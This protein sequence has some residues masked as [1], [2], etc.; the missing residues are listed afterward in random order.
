MTKLFLQRYPG[1]GFS[2]SARWAL[3]CL[4]TLCSSSAVYAQST[5]SGT[6]TDENGAGMPGVSILVKNTTRGTTSGANGEYSISADASEILV[7]SF[8]GYTSVEETVGN[9]TSLDVKLEPNIEALNEVVVIGY[10]TAKKS[11]VTGALVR[12]DEKTI[13]DIPTPSISLAMQGRAAG[14]E[15]QRT[16]SRP[17]AETQIRIRGTRS[18]GSPD[19][20]NNNPLIVVDGIPYGGNINDLNPSDIASIDILKDASATAIYGSRGSNGVILISTK[21]GRPG[22][23]EISYDGYVGVASA[24]DHYDVYNGREYAK[25]VEYTGTNGGINGLL[26]VERE[27]IQMGRQ[28]D[29]QDLVYKR[30]I[31]TNHDISLTG[32]TENTRFSMAA[33]YFKE[34]TVLPGQAFQRY[35]IRGTLDQKVGD[36][37]SVGLNTLNSISFRDGESVDPMFQILTISPL[38][39]PYD[40]DGNVIS[41]PLINGLETNLRS[42]LLL[43]DED[44]W[45]QQ[46]RRIRTF[47]SLYG[48]VKIVEGLRYRVN[49]GLDFWQDEYGHFYGANTPM[50]SGQTNEAV[51]DNRDNWMYTLENLLL[52]DK[53]FNE[54][55]KVNFTGLF[56]VQEDENNN[57]RIQM[58]DVKADFLQYYNLELADT[59]NAA[60]GGYARSGLMSYMARAV[61][62]FDDRFIVTLTGRADGSSRLAKGNKWFYYPAAALAWN[63]T[64]E[65]FMQGIEAVSNL[66]V[67]AGFGMTSNQA[68]NPY[69]SL[70]AL[71][72]MPYSYGANGA[73]GFLVE[74]TPNPD[75]SWEFTTTTNIGLEFGFLQNRIT[76]SLDLYQSNT[77]DIL[78]ERVL[79]ISA[80]IPGGFTQNIGKS[81]GKG[82]ELMLS[83]TNIETQDF[84]WNT[85][86]NL[87]IHRE[88]ITELAGDQKANDASGWFVG[89]PIDV[90][91]DYKKT[92]IWQL[93][94]KEEA[95][96]FGAVPG[97]IKIFDKNGNGQIEANDRMV[98][99]S[100]LP[101]WQGGMTN[102][103]SYKGFDVAIV[104]FWRYGGM[105]VSQLHQ[106]NQSFPIS[107]NEGR[108]N[109]FKTNYWRTDNPTNDFPRPGQ[110]QPLYGSTLGYFDGTFLKIR[111]INIGYRLPDS[112]L[113]KTGLN[114]VRI[115]SMIQNP[116]Q[117]MFSPYVNDGNGIDPEASG[118]G[119]TNTPGYGNR[120][121]V[122]VNTPPTRQFIFGI[123]LK[124]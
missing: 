30:G 120:L 91:F 26:P 8:I 62:G 77:D 46:R 53:T 4:M 1:L 83:S 72:R 15:I 42:P 18:M 14:V 33:G 117:A 105:L 21:R 37:I 89:H 10:G 23:T 68:I 51:V 3:L 54:K 84:T 58:S 49:I 102:R 35:T 20:A 114:S 75:L 63:V 85:D 115:Y 28:T 94:E 44:L 36:R 108:R 93:D 11:D 17:G 87:A 61:Y 124:Y 106:A 73:V 9:R 7:F 45:K 95:A 99:G 121:S 116:F 57:T 111:S 113:G 107:N 96:T 69:Q 71:Q 29:W 65:S 55:H 2:R 118:R 60:T 78:Q 82:I 50:R 52:F 74:R 40:A 98:I 39:I 79:P 112:W 6:I 122:R 5:V 34:S 67:R 90:I 27:S 19:G 88:E 47:N 59:Y 119:S 13:K 31:I 86:F 104:A 66:R 101:K 92:G 109:G 110:Q 22:K 48:E 16:S 70:G 24:I 100:L 76:G 64:N 56:S 123:S 41:R 43:Y 38:A 81:E 12:V 25:L 80:G 103:F 32:G 97:D